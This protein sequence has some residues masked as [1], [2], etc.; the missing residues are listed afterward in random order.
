MLDV[1]A[2]AHPATDEHTAEAV[3]YCLNLIEGPKSAAERTA[4]VAMAVGQRGYTAAELEAIKAE[5]PFRNNFGQGFRPDLADE[6]V[7]ASRRDR[8]ALASVCDEDT[9]LRLCRD[10]DDLSTPDFAVCGFDARN[11]PRSRYAPNAGGDSAPNPVPMEPVLSPRRRDRTG[12][13]DA[14]PLPQSASGLLGKS[15]PEWEH[16]LQSAFGK[17]PERLAGDAGAHPPEYHRHAGRRGGAGTRWTR[18]VGA[19][20]LGRSRLLPA[21]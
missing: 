19:R 13:P 9:M 15:W 18:P 20:S 17:L 1:E 7:Q 8:Q 6:I 14:A 3:S 21:G 11:R 2:W 10:H 12:D 4:I 5:L 16:Y